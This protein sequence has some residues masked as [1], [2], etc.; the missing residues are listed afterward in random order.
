MKIREN[1]RY[2]LWALYIGILIFRSYSNALSNLSISLIRVYTIFSIGVPLIIGLLLFIENMDLNHIIYA[3]F[4][5]VFAVI[6]KFQNAKILYLVL[7]FV[8]SYYS[9]KM[10]IYIYRLG[11]TIGFF[12]TFI[13]GYLVHNLL[14]NIDGVFSFGFYN[15]NQTGFFLALLAIL[16]TLKISNEF[17]E[18]R[19]NIYNISFFLMIVFVTV[20][21][22]DDRTAEL[23]LGSYILFL[24]LRK[25]F[26]FKL[27]KIVLSIFPIFISAFSYWCA[28]NYGSSN[29]LGVINKLS[30]SRLMMWHYYFIHQPIT[31]LGNP[32][33]VIKGYTPGE[34]LFDGG[35]A[36]LLFSFGLLFS[37]II[38]LGLSLANYKFLVNNDNLLLIL[39]LVLEIVAFTENHP[40]APTACFMSLFALMAYLPNW[41]YL[42]KEKNYER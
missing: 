20:K 9:P 32:I 19:L 17:I 26:K 25:I 15:E 12:L 22:F 14:S 42:S 13:G 16:T 2:Y 29:F 28:Q 35:Y 1:M 40:I 33:I 11:I 41:P 36:F 37:L 3:F 39:M 5:L 10:I 31:L 7:A 23:M 34:G 30:T 6:F 8:M 27:V 18:V 21:L 24:L 4:L 38:F